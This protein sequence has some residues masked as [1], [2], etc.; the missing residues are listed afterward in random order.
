MDGT[1]AR[2]RPML[3]LGLRLMTA[4]S[5]ATMGALLKL[6]QQRGAHLLELIFWRQAITF[7]LIGGFMYFA[8]RI[9]AVKTT[10]LNA[11]IRRSVLG[12][13]GM[14]FV[15]GA[16]IL[17]PLAEATAISFTAPMFAVFLSMI[18]FAERI[19]KYRVA[20]I[21]IGFAGV[22]F[23]VQPGGSGDINMVGVAVGLVA[24]FLVALI[25][26]QI[27]DLN[28]TESPWA[29]VF[30]FTAL[31]SPVAALALPFVWTAHDT[32]TWQL[33]LAVAVCGAAAQMLLTSSLRYG[34]AATIIIMDYTSI[35]WATAFGYFLFDRIPPATLAIGAPLI[36]A[37]GL[38]V[39]WRE[40]LLSKR[41]AMKTAGTK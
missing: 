28:K 34:S 9:A 37:S 21:A 19:G 38:L 27:Q 41:A 4:L 10:R 13:I 8:G 3:A 32:A 15:Y 14:V 2:P 17:L 20:A 25:S 22:V 24:A 23:V 18:L 11:H 6:A 12:I 7:M 5:L 31:T 30:W 33:I 29:I 16:V 1:I 39:A 26:I 40:R 35:I 36:I